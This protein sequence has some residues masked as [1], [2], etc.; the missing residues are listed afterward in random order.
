MA[1][2]RVGFNNTEAIKKKKA[3]PF[4]LYLT[5]KYANMTLFGKIILGEMM[6]LPVPLS[7]RKTLSDGPAALPFI[8]LDLTLITPSFMRGPL[9]DKVYD[10][11]SLP[12]FKFN[13]QKLL[14]VFHLSNYLMVKTEIRFQCHLQHSSVISN[15]PVS[16]P[17]FQYHLQHSSVISNI[18]VCRQLTCCFENKLLF[19]M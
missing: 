6:C 1:K 4:N 17:T 19:I 9:T 16:S 7:V 15:I 8:M 5:Y 14:V 10:K 12:P 2:V 13:I 11:N 3:S 18:P